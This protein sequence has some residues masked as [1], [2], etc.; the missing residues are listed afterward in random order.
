MRTMIAS[1]RW[2]RGGAG[3]S[4]PPCTALLCLCCCLQ[5]PFRRWWT[6][7]AR[8]WTRSRPARLLAWWCD[9]VASA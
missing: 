2:A 6:L 3:R 8:P 7:R 9:H 5:Y 4:S 1:E